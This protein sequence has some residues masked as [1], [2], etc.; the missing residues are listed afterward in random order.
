MQLPTVQSIT[1]WVNR[2]AHTLFTGRWRRVVT[3]VFL[4]L[5]AV[6]IL[7]VLYGNRELLRTYE[8]HIQPYWL[9]IATLVMFGSMFLG[10]W[11]WHLVAKRMAGVENGRLNLKIW[12][13]ANLA[14]RIPGVV[15]YIASR[16]ILYEQ[17]GVSKRTTSL[18]SGLELALIFVSGIITTLLTLPFWILPTEITENLGRAWFLLILLPLSFLLIQPRILEKI[19]QKL[20]HETNTHPLR[21]RDTLYWLGFYVIIWVLGGV[22]MFSTINFFQTLPATQLLATI[23][24]WALASSVSLAGAITFTSIGVREVSLT[25]LLTQLMPL[26]VAIITIIAIRLLWLAGELI[27]AVISLKLTPTPPF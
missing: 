21:W 7:T 6:V 9:L 14:K 13:Y 20:S 18:L 17:A 26:P 19:W 2:V 16:A 5:T 24:M 10:G 3:G 25:L 27:T 12:W 11:A 4:G 1:H 23:G 22:V 15:W 8:W